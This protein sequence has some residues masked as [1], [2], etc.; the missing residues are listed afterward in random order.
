MES[1][2]RLRKLE[3]TEHFVQQPDR[4][5]GLMRARIIRRDEIADPI[6]TADHPDALPDYRIV[7][8]SGTGQIEQEVG[9][10]HRHSSP[11]Q[12]VMPSPAA[13]SQR[14]APAGDRIP[15]ELMT[16]QLA[17]VSACLSTAKPE[18]TLHD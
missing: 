14:L 4:H 6:D 7:D 2:T 3:R 5:D 8:P 9:P 15:S 13:I 18:L 11:Q 12:F 10:S 1:R 17:V 16:Q